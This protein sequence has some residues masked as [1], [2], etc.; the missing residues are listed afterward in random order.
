MEL[1]NFPPRLA[2]VDGTF[3]AIWAGHFTSIN[4][5][6]NSST[7]IENVDLVAKMDFME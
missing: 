6:Y 2:L 4:A 5:H 3:E 1:D 7:P